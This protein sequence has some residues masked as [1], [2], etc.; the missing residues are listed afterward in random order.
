LYQPERAQLA[1]FVSLWAV[2]RARLF[3]S[4]GR[5]ALLMDV[6]IRKATIADAATLTAIA[7]AAKRHW[8]YAEQWF[9]VWHEAL[10]IAESTVD[11]MPVFVADLDGQTV[12]FYA[13]ETNG[14]DLWL[15]HLWIVPDLLGR[16]IGSRLFA[17]AVDVARTS[18]AKWLTIESDPY[19][20]GFYLRMGARRSGT[21][22]AP[23]PGAPDRCLPVL[24]YALGDAGGLQ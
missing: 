11:Q 6:Q 23:M 24:A 17:H 7:H 21:V 13:L 4:F 3:L 12:G 16:G 2:A 8:G 10:T 15:E 22:S 19:A 9:D 20:E 5:Y 14:N 18:G 1:W